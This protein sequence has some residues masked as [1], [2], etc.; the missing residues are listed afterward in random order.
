MPLFAFL[1]ELM[2]QFGIALSLDGWYFQVVQAIQFLPRDQIE[3]IYRLSGHPVLEPICGLTQMRFWPAE[4]KRDIPNVWIAFP[5]DVCRV[6]DLRLYIS[7][8]LEHVRRWIIDGL[9]TWP[10]HD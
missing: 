6:Q 4:I 8:E 9:T 7:H 2:Q 10:G 3:S 5:D 1:A